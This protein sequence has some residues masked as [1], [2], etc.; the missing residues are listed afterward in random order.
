MKKITITFL[1]G[2]L[3]LF[4]GAGLAAQQLVRQGSYQQPRQARQQYQAHQQRYY[5]PPE[6]TDWQ[7]LYYGRRPDP[8]SGLQYRWANTP[9]GPRS[10]PVSFDRLPPPHFYHGGNPG[11]NMGGQQVVIIQN[12]GGYQ[13]MDPQ[14]AI[15]MGSFNTL[16]QLLRWLLSPK[17]VQAGPAPLQ[18]P[19]PCGS[20][21]QTQTSPPSVQEAPAT[22]PKVLREGVYVH[23]DNADAVRYTKMSY[24]RRSIMTVED[25]ATTAK[26]VRVELRTGD[27]RAIVYLEVI[28]LDSPIRRSHNFSGSKYY[29][30]TKDPLANE[31]AKLDAIASASEDAVGEVTGIKK[32][33]PMV[34]SIKAGQQY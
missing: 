26:E 29:K 14:T 25:G 5:A 3:F 27:P 8:P 6:Q 32:K 23:G 21:L 2:F 30:L 11:Y 33:E 15:V 1:V 20:C 9:Y 22:A 24:R 31:D 18:Q 28:D 10:V 34:S 19:S 17:L 16:Q 7:N 13:M 4:S 12:G